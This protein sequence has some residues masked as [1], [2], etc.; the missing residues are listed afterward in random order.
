[1]KKVLI[2]GGNGYIAKSLYYSLKELCDVSIISRKDFDLTDP[3]ETLNFFS[4]KHF[5]V[6]LH[7]AVSGGNRLK[8]DN[9][10]VVD[11]NLRMY[12]NL[13]NCKNKFNRFINFGSGAE[14]YQIDK[15]YGLSK[16]II[17]DSIL[18]KENFYNIRIFAVFDE[19]ELDTR[20]IKSNIKRYIQK[21]NLY[22][23]DDKEMDFF[24]MEDFTI[25]VKYF[26]FSDTNKLPKTY[27]C[28]YNKTFKTSQ[29]LHI[30]NTLDDYKSS[31]IVDGKNSAPYKG[32][33]IDLGVKYVGLENGIKNLYK[34]LRLKYGH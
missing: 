6:V 9:F 27:E 17:H 28:T 2:T 24:Y 14:I 1:M 30:V 10:D 26:I 19:N 29:I 32:E 34:I 11:N 15:P 20:F 12:Y 16:K 31:I 3:F 5:D 21:E 23:F 13:L 7:C 8:N 33:F 18:E 4:N 25:L 22:V